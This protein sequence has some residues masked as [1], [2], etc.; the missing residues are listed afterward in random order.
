MGH[1]Q[2]LGW[3]KF[4]TLLPPPEQQY[5]LSALQGFSSHDSSRAFALNRRKW[6][7]ILTR[8]SCGRDSTAEFGITV[9]PVICRRPVRCIGATPEQCVAP[10]VLGPTEADCSVL[11]LLAYKWSLDFVSE[12]CAGVADYKLRRTLVGKA[13]YFPK[14]DVP[15]YDEREARWQSTVPPGERSLQR[16]I[17]PDVF[18]FKTPYRSV[19][20]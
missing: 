15:A 10:L 13:Q 1:R 8:D 6:T 17:E 12:R 19:S 2:K 18:I 11:D 4:Q 20:D 5:Q 9:D 16:C 7:I 3:A 14:V